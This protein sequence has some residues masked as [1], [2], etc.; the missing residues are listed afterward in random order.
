MGLLT[1]RIDDSKT[2]HYHNEKYEKIVTYNRATVQESHEVLKEFKNET[3]DVLNGEMEVENTVLLRPE[4]EINSDGRRC[5]NMFICNFKLNDKEIN[6]YDELVND[7]R[8]EITERKVVQF[9]NKI[10]PKYLL[11]KGE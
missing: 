2:S 3:R 9:L 1:T 7:M 11:D 10:L 5:R 4:I 6:C 8:Y